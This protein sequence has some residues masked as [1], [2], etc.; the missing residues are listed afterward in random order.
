MLSD[1]QWGRRN[2]EPRP[3]F[4]V[5]AWMVSLMIDWPGEAGPGMCL[6][7]G[8]TGVTTEGCRRLGII[9]VTTE[10]CR[11]M[12]IVHDRLL[13]LRERDLGKGQISYRKPTQG[14]GRVEEHLSLHLKW[15]VGGRAGRPCPCSRANT[16]YH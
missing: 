3:S 2:D 15:R 11:R 10:G 8:V 16:G 6:D 1:F 7:E 14:S 5:S 4:G 12:R 13:P 9:G